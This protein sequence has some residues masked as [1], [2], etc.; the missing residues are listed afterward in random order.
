MVEVYEV[1]T[2]NKVKATLTRTPMTEAT[3]RVRESQSGIIYALIDGVEDSNA[4]LTGEDNTGRYGALEIVENKDFYEGA[5]AYQGWYKSA[6]YKVVPNMPLEEGAHTMS[7]SHSD[8]TQTSEVE[9]NVI[10]PAI[11]NNIGTKASF[12]YMPVLDRYISGVPTISSKSFI[13]NPIEVQQ[14]VN[15]FYKIENLVKVTSEDVRIIHPDVTED[16]SVWLDVGDIPSKPTAE[17]G[18]L[19]TSDF[20][21][22][23]QGKSKSVEKVEFNLTGHGITGEAGA[24][25]TLVAEGIRIDDSSETSRV[26]SGKGTQVYPRATDQACEPWDETLNILPTSELQM[27]GGYYQWPKGDYTKVGGPDYTE[28]IG[29]ILEGDAPGPLANQWRWVTFKYDVKDLR[30]FHLNIQ[31]ETPEFVWPSDINKSILDMKIVVKA[32]GATGWVDANK[33]YPGYSNAFRVGDGALDVN[34]TDNTSRKITFGAAS[35]PYSGSLFVRIGIT[36]NSQYKISDNIS[37]NTIE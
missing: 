33:A 16:N 4:E 18:S 36:K 10:V 5:P 7:I 14:V 9:V 12:E 24:P 34:M 3:S 19:F 15:H 13:M 31:G 21:F 8:G 35:L 1:G 25:Y 22:A 29:S 23:I 37:I 11:S 20:M 27:L 2:G 6:K 32:G 30:A 28:A 17:Y 26:T